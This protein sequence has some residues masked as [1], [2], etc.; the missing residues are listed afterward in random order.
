MM[1]LPKAT[2]IALALLSI[3]AGIPALAGEVAKVLV[4]LDGEEDATVARRICRELGTMGLKAETIEAVADGPTYRRLE[5]LARS[6]GALAV[7]QI[8]LSSGTLEVWVADRVTGKVV[9]RS[10]EVVAGNEPAASVV[11]MEAV[12]L[13]RASLMELHSARPPKGEVKPT[14]AISEFS[15]PPAPENTP[16]PRPKILFIDLGPALS[17]PSTDSGPS[18]GLAASFHGRL[19]RRLRLGIHGLVPLVAGSKSVPEGEIK[20]ASGLVA[21]ELLVALNKI[22]A[23]VIPELG[24]GF[25]AAFFRVRGIASTGFTPGE[26]TL[27][28]AFPYMKAEL[29]IR[30]TRILALRGG[31][32]IGWTTVANKVQV[33]QRDVIE[34]GRPWIIVSVGL[35]IAIW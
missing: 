13:L 6:N 18:M 20:V 15:E 2:F 22:D 34:L 28:S 11:A 33:A 5:E 12:E 31:A 14:P 29:S 19:A 27:T 21:A 17:F 30:L 3:C 4:V 10:V 25:G 26:F 16:P 23:R 1:N 9:Y 32:S 35:A 8:E 24:A 7:I